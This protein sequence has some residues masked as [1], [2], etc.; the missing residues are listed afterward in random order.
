MPKPEPIEPKPEPITPKA[1]DAPIAVDSQPTETQ[2]A[3]SEEANEPTTTSKSES[4]PKAAKLNSVGYI[5]HLTLIS[6]LLYNS[7]KDGNYS[8]FI[9]SYIS[10][11]K[12]RI[13]PS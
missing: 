5:G 10:E 1:E 4:K 2:L 9:Q 11:C 12:H 13:C 7:T 8:K 3:A 6:N